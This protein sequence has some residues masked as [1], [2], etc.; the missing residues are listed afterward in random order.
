MSASKAFSL[1]ML[2]AA[3]LMASACAT[4]SSS[5]YDAKDVGRTVETTRASVVSSRLVNIS[6]ETSYVGPA[7]GGALG[8]ATAGLASGSTGWWSIVG[9]VAGAGAG[10]LAEKQI[11]NRQ[12][13]E[14]VVHMNDGRTVTLVQN[15]EGDEFPIPNGTPVLVQLGGQYTRVIPD[16]TGGRDAG[17]AGSGGGWSDPD[18][19]PAQRT[20]A[21]PA[22]SANDQRRFMQ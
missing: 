9:A 19:M 8:A 15:R 5:T 7:A 22:G 21:P 14:Y 4:S 11:G 13:I 18:T 10:Y 20:P 2:L 6:G 3:T 16:P 17:G 12:G 1:P